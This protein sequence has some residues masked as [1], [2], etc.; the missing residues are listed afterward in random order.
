MDD[1]WQPLSW[2]KN[3][4]QNQIRKKSDTKS[5]TESD[6]EPSDQNV[7]KSPP[8]RGLKKLV[9]N[10]DKKRVSVQNRLSSMLFKQ[11]EQLKKDIAKKRALLEKEL[12]VEITKEVESLKQ[13]A[14]DKLNSQKSL[15]RK[16]TLSE[17][18][19]PQTSPL[20][21]ATKKR[22]KSDKTLA[23][24]PQNEDRDNTDNIPGIKKDRMYCVCKTK[25]DPA[26]FYVGC[27]ICSNWF[28][29]SCVGITP[30]MSKK[31]S[32]YV[33]DECRSAKE[34]DEIYCLCRQPYDDSQF[35][36]GCEKCEDWFHGRCVGILQSEAENIEEY[37]CPRC[38]PNSRLNYP[39][40]KKLNSKDHELIKETFKAIQNNR[41][42]QPFKEPVNPNV[43]P[44]Y[45]EIVKEP[46][47]LQTIEGRVNYNQYNCLAE[48]I[49]DITRIFEN[50]RYFNPQGTGV[51]K[52]AENLEIF[53]AQKIEGVR[54]KVTLNK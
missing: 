32:E 21:A 7:P 35:Y 49:G 31:M 14:Q 46:M 16:R 40:L 25:Y 29:G 43:N 24:S 5:D 17:A 28:H 41:N 50:C 12:S 42:S 54:E 13:Q 10:E 47:D 33:C 53:L 4:I 27:D 1:E 11:K 44:K 37:V 26:K 36:I 18:Q 8:M 3:K 19:S 9:P 52:A 48:F 30:K 15:H 20:A 34:N 45:Y 38:E 39:N 51:A 22:R 23:H 2:Q 6:F